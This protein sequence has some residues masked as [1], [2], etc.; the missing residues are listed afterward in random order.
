MSTTVLVVD[1]SA[2]VRQQV[3]AALMQVGFKVVEAAD[4]V[5]GKQRIDQGGIDCVICD[6][7]MPNKNGIEMLEEVKQQARHKSLPIVMLTTE[8]APGVIQRAKLAGAAGWIVKPF[9]ADMLIAAV[10]KLTNS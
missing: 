5:Q 1:D 8:G 2:T 7:N 6:V 3:G 10:R 4:G 9:K